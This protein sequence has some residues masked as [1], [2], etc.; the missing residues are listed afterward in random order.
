[1]EDYKNIKGI[2]FDYW[3]IFSPNIFPIQDT[4]A[5]KGIDKETRHGNKDYIDAINSLNLGLINEKE[6]IKRCGDIFKVKL[7]YHKSRIKF[8]KTRLNHNLIEIVQKL[9]GKYKIGLLSNN[10]ETFTKEYLFKPKLDKLFDV[11]VLSHLEGIRKPD[12]KIY[13]LLAKRMGL[14]PEEILYIDDRENRAK[15]AEE[16]GFKTLIY[17]GKKTDKILQSLI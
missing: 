12:P 5:E 6:Y 14:K 7:P 1:M 2:A 10:S 3:G 4:L 11:M 16:L 13:L 9:K 15:P 17:E 8:D